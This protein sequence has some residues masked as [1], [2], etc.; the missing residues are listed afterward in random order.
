MPHFADSVFPL[1]SPVGPENQHAAMF[2]VRMDESQAAAHSTDF[3]GAEMHANLRHP[4]GEPC[5]APQA[6]VRDPALGSR[7]HARPGRGASGEA[8]HLSRPAA[9]AFKYPSS[10]PGPHAELKSGPEM[11]GRPACSCTDGS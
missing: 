10:S 4:Q 2:P 11:T 8:I 6:A 5:R 7:C 1:S 9:S 3:K